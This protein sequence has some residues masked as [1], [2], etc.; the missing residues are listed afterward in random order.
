M[1]AADNLDLVLAQAINPLDPEMNFDAVQKLCQQILLSR[2]APQ[3]ILKII[4]HKIQSPQERE[5]LRALEVLEICVSRC[6]GKLNNEVGKF[7]FLN[8][9]I[10]VVSPKYLGQRAPESVKRRVVEI[11]YKWSV[12]L[13]HETK[14]VDAYQMLKRQGVVEDDPIHVLPRQEELENVEVLPPRE[15][16]IF[17]DKRKENELKRL[18]G[19][20]N[21]KDLQAANRLIKT[22]VEEADHKMD[23][24][25][26]KRLDLEEAVN[27]CAVFS[28]LLKN[29]SNVG[30]KTFDELELLRQMFENCDT[31]RP[32]LFT[33]ATEFSLIEDFPSVQDVLQQ[34]DQLTALINDYKERVAP[35]VK[36]GSSTRVPAEPQP[37]ETSSLLTGINSLS[38]ATAPSKTIPSELSDLK[39]D[40]D[41]LGVPEEKDDRS[42]VEDVSLLDSQIS[43]CSIARPAI[44]TTMTSTTAATSD[45]L[46]TIDTSSKSNL[47]NL[48]DLNIAPLDHSS[49]ASASSVE[50]GVSSSQQTLEPEPVSPKGC[51]TKVP[52]T[53]TLGQQQLASKTYAPFEGLDAMMT[54]KI[55][56]EKSAAR[57]VPATAAKCTNRVDLAA[58]PDIPLADVLPSAQPPL[59]LSC[60]DDVTAILSV[61]D[62]RPVEGVVVVLV[63]ATNRNSKAAVKNF[64]CN[65]SVRDGRSRSQHPSG[66]Q[67]PIFN[68]YLPSTAITQIIIL[69]KCT[70]RVQLSFSISYTLFSACDQQQRTVS[71]SGEKTI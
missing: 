61:T 49:T 19:S 47:L 53:T 52:K 69:E 43:P 60:Q 42:R 37:P 59:V 14:I 35:L 7:R 48:M 16:E 13:S 39:K 64:V 38:S 67:L 68:A 63:T 55:L 4:A 27:N 30:T 56:S 71:I 1:A 62:N 22:M 6:G 54:E 5:A 24:K 18:L 12:V 21:P 66:D 46:I 32:K 9:L 20:K 44:N 11:L 10:R 34:N 17:T 70:E 2:D 8:E 28:D 57:T 29:F 31:L 40:F 51:P 41:P 36:S 26:R 3:E 65:I 15:D 58:V 45:A 50:A 23:L 33:L 25:A